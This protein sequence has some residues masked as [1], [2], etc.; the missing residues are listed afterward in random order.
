MTLRTPR[1]PV[2]Y[3]PDV[4]RPEPDEAE[5]GEKLVATMRK[6]ID[7]THRDTGRKLRSVHAKSHA[8]LDGELRV[9]DDLPDVLRQG[10]F[11]RPARYRV[12]MRFSTNP[13]DILPDSVSVPR[14]LAIKISGVEGERLPG[15]EGHSSQDLVLVNAPAFLAPTA[16]KFLGSLK[17][18]AATTDKAPGAK[19]A[20]SAVLRGVERG[21][22]AVGLESPTI[23]SIGGHPM[24]HPL[25]ETYFTQT[26]FRY[27]DYITKLAVAP[28][29]PELEALTNAAL[30]VRGRRDGLREALI[31]FFRTQGGR[32]EVR[33]QLCTD[34]D[35]MPIEDASVVWPEDA[36]P[37][38]PVAEITVPAQPA[39]SEA[40][41]ATVDDG[42]SFSPWHG[43]Q[44]HRPLG[45]INRTRKAAYEMSAEFRGAKADRDINDDTP[46]QK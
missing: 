25:G 11:A 6:I 18:L 44:A 35:T 14:G 45:S 41:S 8:L 34:L 4:E 26:P 7:V 31:D 15:S 46:R 9:L 19:Q 2:R 29:S 27:G 21:I 3:S 12:V 20:L 1:E 38:L 23:T 28:G 42:L 30:D 39:W 13:G 36:S 22:E 43:L 40:R 24:T 17:L 32:W 16:K 10:V 37:Y 33:V 5:T